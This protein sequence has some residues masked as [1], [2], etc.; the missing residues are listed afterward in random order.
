MTVLKWLWKFCD[1]ARGTA[2]L[3]NSN[4]FLEAQE[5]QQKPE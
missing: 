5:A 2:F 4:T 1:P 3:A